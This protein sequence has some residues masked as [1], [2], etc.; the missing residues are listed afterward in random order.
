MSDPTQLPQRDVLA[1][2]HAYLT[3]EDSSAFVLPEL[4]ESTQVFAQAFRDAGYAGEIRIDGLSVRTLSLDDATV[5]A[6]QTLVLDRRGRIREVTQELVIQLVQRDGWN[7]CDLVVDG[8]SVLASSRPV[9]V[10]PAQADGIDIRAFARTEPPGHQVVAIAVR[11]ESAHPVALKCASATSKRGPLRYAAEFSRK[12]LRE[13][14]A[15]DFEPMAERA[16][17]LRLPSRVERLWLKV[18][19]GTMRGE[20][21]FALSP[22]TSTA[23]GVPRLPRAA[24]LV[25]RLVAPVGFIAAFIV[26]VGLWHS[27]LTALVVACVLAANGLFFSHWNVVRLERRLARQRAETRALAGR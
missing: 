16:V 10:E 4:R 7:V 14:G 9:P 21:L 3:S 26:V 12:N 17:A 19:L 5:D 23:E 8:V 13:G 11:N 20:S 2:A 24:A 18:T 22:R 25:R 27:F 1:V 6:R 15:V